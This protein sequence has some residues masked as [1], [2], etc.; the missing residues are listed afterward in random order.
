MALPNLTRE[1]A[2]ERAALVTVD[3]YRIALDL[4]EGDPV[5][6]Y[7]DERCALGRLVACEVGKCHVGQA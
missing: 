2:A 3:N 7:C 1:Q 4:T 6:V 5:V